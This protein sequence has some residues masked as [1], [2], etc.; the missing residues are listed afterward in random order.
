MAAVLVGDGECHDGTGGEADFTCAAFG[1][2]DGGDCALCESDEIADCD[3]VC[4]PLAKLGDGV[5]DA[6]LDCLRLEGDAGDCCGAGELRSC[7]ATG[8]AT[9][10]DAGWVGDAICDDALNCAEHGFDGGHCTTLDGCGEGSIGP[11]CGACRAGGHRRRVAARTLEARVRLG[12][13]RAIGQRSV[14]SA[15]GPFS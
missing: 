4:V 14:A 3:E 8:V 10:V 1:G 11:M 6:R 9:C 5:C 7:G 12:L 2:D 13:Y 15:Y